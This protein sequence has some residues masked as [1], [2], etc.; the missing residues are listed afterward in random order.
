MFTFTID[1]EL[2]A[3]DIMSCNMGCNHSLRLT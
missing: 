3:N 1:L 2:W